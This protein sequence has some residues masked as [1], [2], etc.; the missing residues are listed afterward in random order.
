[1]NGDSPSLPTFGSYPKL[2]R[3]YAVSCPLVAVKECD[4]PPVVKEWD[5]PEES[6]VGGRMLRIA[7]GVL[8]ELVIDCRWD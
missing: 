1:L 3:L 7:G 5:G 4:G 8:T 6:A 2:P